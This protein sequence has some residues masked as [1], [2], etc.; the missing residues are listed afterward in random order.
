VRISLDTEFWE[1]SRPT[2]H[3]GPECN[4]VRTI[5]L[6]SIGLAADSGDEYYAVVD[7]LLLIQRAADQNPWLRDNVISALPVVAA[8]KADATVWWWN[9]DHPDS[10]H[11]KP[12]AQIV[13]EVRQF[14]LSYPDPSLWASFGAYDHVVTCWLW[15]SMAD[16]PA[17]IPMRTN[18]VEQEWER[19]GRPILPEQ[20][21]GQHHAL[22]DARHVRR[23]LRVLD[24]LAD[25]ARSAS[26]AVMSGRR[27]VR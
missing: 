9:L 25:P 10:E 22:A 27:V 12:R 11:V 15:G 8:A 24:S 23:L 5:D 6:L 19:Q 1:H 21:F 17:G 14:I 13:D 2:G 3:C 26:K 16:L 4:T 20:R 18:D 7:D